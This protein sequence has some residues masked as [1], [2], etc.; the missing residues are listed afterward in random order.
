MKSDNPMKTYPFFLLIFF[1][2]LSTP[3]LYSQQLVNDKYKRRQLESMVVT[4]WGKFTPN[5]YYV[6]FHNKYRKGE[7]RRTML[8]LA[9]TLA[10]VD[11]TKG[12]SDEEKEDTNQLF[13]Q[14]VSLQANIEME[15]PYHLYFEPKFSTLRAELETLLISCIYM[16]VDGTAISA[17]HSERDRLF[18][19]ITIIRD[20]RLTNGEAFE[21]YAEIERELMQLRGMIHS[22]IHHQEVLFK[23]TRP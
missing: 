21:A 11:I 5:W 20:G 18:G 4:R 1:L 12:Q 13:D 17:F 9:P 3:P 16:Q 10:A 19:Q 6:L 15:L 23:F 22:Y 14:S 8:Q 2:L 7:D